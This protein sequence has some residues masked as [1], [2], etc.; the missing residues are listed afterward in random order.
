MR[1]LYTASTKCLYSIR[2]LPTSRAEIPNPADTCSQAAFGITARHAAKE[3]TLPLLGA[4]L[5]HCAEWTSVACLPAFH[6]PVRS[7]RLDS[8]L[9]TLPYSHKADSLPYPQG[10][11]NRNVHPTGF[12]PKG[13]CDP[14][15]SCEA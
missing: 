1:I 6:L 8:P 2:V 3:W 7:F 13:A 15:R 10:F 11:T 14:G 12:G 4:E 5:P 9:G